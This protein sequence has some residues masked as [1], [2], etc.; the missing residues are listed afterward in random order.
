MDGNV[1]SEHSILGLSM[2]D[3]NEIEPGCFYL[4]PAIGNYFYCD[5]IDGDLIK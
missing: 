4:T 5:S 3:V 2:G 1:V